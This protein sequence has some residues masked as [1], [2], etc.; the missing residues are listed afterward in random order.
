MRGPELALAG[1]LLLAGCA[2][3]SGKID[4]DSVREAPGVDLEEDTGSSPVEGCSRDA[5]IHAYPG[6][7]VEHADIN[8]LTDVK[9][10]VMVSIYN[11]GNEA[12][13]ETELQL[14][15]ND[16]DFFLDVPAIDSEGST[17]VIQKGLVLDGDGDIQFTAYIGGEE[18]SSNTFE[19]RQVGS[20]LI[21]QMAEYLADEMGGDIHDC[22]G[23]SD[24]GVPQES[25]YC[26]GMQWADEQ[27]VFTSDYSGGAEY[28]T[29]NHA[30]LATAVV[31]AFPEHFDALGEPCDLDP[32]EWYYGSMQAFQTAFPEIDFCNPNA[33]TLIHHLYGTTYPSGGVLDQL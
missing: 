17:Q 5:Y 16:G 9:N 6:T 19:S 31:R 21:G 22:E 11:V 24:N 33:D 26:E 7:F 14:S 23:D 2:P 15:S 18:V 13:P 3:S 30:T 29:L 20:V 1:S 32:S 27:E 12:C 4:L 28:N 10:T 8:P 25:S